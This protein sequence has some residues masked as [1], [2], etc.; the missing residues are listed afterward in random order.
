MSAVVIT[1]MGGVKTTAKPM[2]VVVATANCTLEPCTDGPETASDG[3]AAHT[4]STNAQSTAR[5]MPRDDLVVSRYAAHPP[6]ATTSHL[7]A[8]SAEEEGATS[9]VTEANALVR[10]R[11]SNANLFARSSRPHARSAR[12]SETSTSVFI[13]EPWLSFRFA[14]SW[15]A[16]RPLREWSPTAPRTGQELPGSPSIVC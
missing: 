6:S 2:T 7:P 10:C 8:G 11:V 14:D 5:R 13:A 9:T 4:A 3:A 15:H 1:E 12:A 16:R